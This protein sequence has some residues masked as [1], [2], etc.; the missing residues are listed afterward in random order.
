MENN[1]IIT[2]VQSVLQDQGFMQLV[3]QNIYTYDESIGI[4]VSGPGGD[5]NIVPTL[6][7]PI[8]ANEN[9]DIFALVQFNTSRAGN[10]L[11]YTGIVSITSTQMNFQVLYPGSSNTDFTLFNDLFPVASGRSGECAILSE[12]NLLTDVTPAGWSEVWMFLLPD[13]TTT[14]IVIDFTTDMAGGTFWTIR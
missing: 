4:A 14:A 11:R 2:Q 7:F 3:F 10:S 6:I 8:G 13:N 1:E 12:A 9:N 5:Y